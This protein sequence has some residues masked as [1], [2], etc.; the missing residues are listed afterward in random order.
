MPYNCN[1]QKNKDPC[2]CLVW[3]D[4]NDDLYTGS[5]LRSAHMKL[6][7]AYNLCALCLITFY[8]PGKVVQ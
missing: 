6:L 2:N 3:L 4:S 1:L 8:A 5:G 7:E